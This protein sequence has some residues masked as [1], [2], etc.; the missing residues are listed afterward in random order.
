M[1]GKD[2]EEDDEDFLGDLISQVE[3]HKA[4]FEK[5][6][7]QLADL[8]GRVSALEKQI[9]ELSPSLKMP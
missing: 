7:K 9:A 3:S 6:S 8:Q 1:K 4:E 5:T 2:K